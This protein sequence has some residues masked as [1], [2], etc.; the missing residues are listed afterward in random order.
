MFDPK[1]IPSPDE[2]VMFL[3]NTLWVS[4]EGKVYR[5]DETVTDSG[6]LSDIFTKSVFDSAKKMAEK[7]KIKK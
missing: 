3:Q 7:I 6:L 1:G 4:L 2:C 5:M